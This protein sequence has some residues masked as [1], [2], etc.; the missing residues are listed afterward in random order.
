MVRARKH[1]LAEDQREWMQR[2]TALFLDQ[3]EVFPECRVLGETTLLCR[4]LVK[5][6]GGLLRRCASLFEGETACIY[7][8]TGECAQQSI[9]SN[10]GSFF[11]IKPLF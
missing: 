8:L 6:L 10:T 2:S 9:L 1:R 11:Y 3:E 4:S 7:L 5:E